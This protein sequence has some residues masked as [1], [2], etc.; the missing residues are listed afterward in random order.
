MCRFVC[1]LY[2]NDKNYL[3]ALCWMRDDLK[4]APVSESATYL[5]IV[6]DKVLSLISIANL[7]GDVENMST[8]RFRFVDFVA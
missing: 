1:F 6:A 4:A 3:N 7:P 5:A 2:C 8:I